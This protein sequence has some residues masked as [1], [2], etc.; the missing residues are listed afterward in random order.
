M[1]YLADNYL[2]GDTD[3]WTFEKVTNDDLIQAFKYWG[4]DKWG[5]S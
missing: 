2:V 1:L 3:D 5:K 4:R